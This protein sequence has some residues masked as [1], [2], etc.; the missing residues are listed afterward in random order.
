MKNRQNGN[1][2]GALSAFT[3]T[4]LIVAMVVLALVVSVTIPIVRKKMEKV[5]YAQYWMGYNAA[6][7]IA[8][9]LPQGDDSSKACD[10]E[11]GNHCWTIVGL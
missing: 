10:V 4:E 9:N 1:G 7:N 3:I 11:F 6:Q 8:K 5:S 2:G